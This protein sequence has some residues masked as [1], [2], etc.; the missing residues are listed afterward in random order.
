MGK[1]STA[2]PATTC[3]RSG[4][5]SGDRDRHKWFTI[6]LCAAK[7]A[8]STIPIVFMLSSGEDPIKCD[9]VAS[10]NRPG[11]NVTGVSAPG[12]AGKQLNL[13]LELNPPGNCNRLSF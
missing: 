11:G 13:L 6:L 5:P 1:S 2:A 12:L 10:F 7:A 8:T 9:L 3:R 4:Q